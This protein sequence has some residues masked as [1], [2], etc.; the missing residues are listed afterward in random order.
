M[1][2]MEATLTGSLHPSLMFFKKLS[3]LTIVYFFFG[4]LLNRYTTC[5]MA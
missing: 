1:K 3:Y 2:Q 4:C 5:N